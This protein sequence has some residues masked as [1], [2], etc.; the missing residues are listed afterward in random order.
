VPRLDQTY[1]DKVCGE[2][3]VSLR[4]ARINGP[5]GTGAAD[6]SMTGTD[7]DRD[8]NAINGSVGSDPS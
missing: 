3:S 2:S 1:E 6:T 7:S 8:T 5:G 4:F